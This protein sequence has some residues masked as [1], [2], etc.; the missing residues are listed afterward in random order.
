LKAGGF[1]PLR[2]RG[3]V[4]SR[5]RPM[6]K[7]VAVSINNISKAYPYFVTWKKWVVNDDVGGEPVVIFHDRGAVS[8]LD[9]PEIVLSREDGSTGV[10]R[11]EV[12]GQLLTFSRNYETFVDDQTG[13]VWDITEQAIQ[14]ELKGKKLSPVAHGDYFAFAWLIFKPETEIYLE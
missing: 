6:E 9:R 13:S 2:Y 1:E 14:G 3:K 5:L 11:R 4:N 12:A 10:F 7:L 8:A